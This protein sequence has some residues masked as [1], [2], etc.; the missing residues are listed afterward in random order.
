MTSEAD[1]S[2]TFSLGHET[3]VGLAES[4]SSPQSTHSSNAYGETSV[5]TA[6]SAADQS[7]KH[8]L[9]VPPKSDAN[10]PVLWRGTCTAT[11]TTERNGGNDGNLLAPSVSDSTQPNI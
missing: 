8:S 11:S 7:E 4:A 1:Y 10:E 5:S 3:Q 6:P 9:W 2:T